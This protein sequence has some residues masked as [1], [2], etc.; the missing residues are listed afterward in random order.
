MYS[1]NISREAVLIGQGSPIGS[2]VIYQKIGQRITDAKELAIIC[3]LGHTHIGWWDKDS[4]QRK[5]P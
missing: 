4:F 1:A 5:C 2:K 3:R